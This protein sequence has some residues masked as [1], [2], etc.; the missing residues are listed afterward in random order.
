[1]ATRTAVLGRGASAGGVSPLVIFTVPAGETWIIKRVD[2]LNTAGAGSA[3]L[4]QTNSVGGALVGRLYANTIAAGAI[5]HW[6][7]WVVLEGGEYLTGHHTQNGVY[8]WV[9]GARLH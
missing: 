2:M 6:E 3:Q 9:S 7:G 8:Y 1:M 4:L 5:D